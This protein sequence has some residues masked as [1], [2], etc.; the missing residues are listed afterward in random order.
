MWVEN[1]RELIRTLET[2]D[3]AEARRKAPAVI[4]AF[5]TI[6]ANARSMCLPRSR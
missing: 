6:L 4:V 2:K 3:P 1:Q 5:G